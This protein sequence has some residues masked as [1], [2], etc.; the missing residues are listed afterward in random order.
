MNSVVPNFRATDKVI[1]SGVADG[2][3]CDA[4]TVVARLTASRSSARHRTLNI[5]NRQAHEVV[6]S[7]LGLRY[8]KTLEP[9]A[10]P[11][12]L[13]VSVSDALGFAYATIKFLPYDKVHNVHPTVLSSAFPFVN[14]SASGCPHHPS[15]LRTVHF[16]SEDSASP[17]SMTPIPIKRDLF[18]TLQLLKFYRGFSTCLVGIFPYAGTGFLTWDNLHT[19]TLVPISQDQRR[20]RATPLTDLGIGLAGTVPHSVLYFRS[21]AES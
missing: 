8:T 18:H 15:F 13:T 20:P 12:A 6:P 17:T 21:R 2:P 14:I 19:A 1:L 4:K 10:L 7:V 11:R 16:I 3:G 5:R 9:Y